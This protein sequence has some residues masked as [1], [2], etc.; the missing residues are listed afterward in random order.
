MGHDSDGED[1]DSGGGSTKVI[2]EESIQADSIK[3]PGP[4]STSSSNSLA[5]E[6][7]SNPTPASLSVTD[8]NSDKPVTILPR[9]SPRQQVG[10]SACV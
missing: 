3:E 10:L 1:S 9:N 4:I 6:Q 2:Q 7:L 5:M 8:E